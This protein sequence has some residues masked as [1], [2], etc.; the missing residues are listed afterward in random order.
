MID[1]SKMFAKF[2]IATSFRLRYSHSTKAS[3]IRRC[4]RLQDYPKGRNCLVLQPGSIA[5]LCII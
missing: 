4:S 1:N 5:P 3:K 2:V